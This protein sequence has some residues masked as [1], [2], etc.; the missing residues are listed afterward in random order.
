M[1]KIVS[2][3]LVWEGLSGTRTGRVLV[4]EFSWRFRWEVGVHRKVGS[5]Q[6][7]EQVLSLVCR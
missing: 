7:R 5:V 4:V 6:G 2:L 1:L 3:A